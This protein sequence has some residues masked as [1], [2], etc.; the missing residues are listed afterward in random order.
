MPVTPTGSTAVMA[1]RTTDALEEDPQRKLWRALDYYPTPPWA[2]RAGGELIK[3]LDPAAKT[4]W[5]PACGEGHM[6]DPLA[7][8]FDGLWASDIHGHGFG[9]VHDFLGGALPS[10]VQAGVDWVITN[11]PFLLAA[12]FLARGL[13]VANRGVALLCRLAFLESE[14]R[15]QLLYG[16]QPVTVVAPFTERVAMQLG[17]W[18]PKG[19]TATAYAWFVWVKGSPIRGQLMPIAPGAKK[20]LSRPADVQ[21]FA[22]KGELPLLGGAA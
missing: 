22:L 5:E 10:E 20:R 1:R 15:Y 7:A 21:R 12:E 3:R 18:N 9:A 2:A 11:P 16:D 14:T 17:S 4:A 8:Y 19:A 13:E 6:A